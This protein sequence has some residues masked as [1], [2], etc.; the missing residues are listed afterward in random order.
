MLTANESWY[1]DA[2]IYEAPVKSFLDANGDGIGDFAGMITK[3]DYIR[4][5]GVDCIWLLPMF[6]SP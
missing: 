3:L 6:P 4:D 2:V 5:L 1:K